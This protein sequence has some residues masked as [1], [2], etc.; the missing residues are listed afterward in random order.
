MKTIILGIVLGLLGCGSSECNHVPDGS[1]VSA[2]GALYT[3]QG[4]LPIGLQG[5]SCAEEACG[6]YVCAQGSNTEDVTV[7]QDGDVVILSFDGVPMQL[8][9]DTAARP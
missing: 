1:Y 8:T 5:W 6:S 4:G 7:Q 9:L 3:F 2:S